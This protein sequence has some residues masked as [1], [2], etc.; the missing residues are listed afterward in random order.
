M[1]K[2]LLAGAVLLSAPLYAQSAPAGDVPSKDSKAEPKPDKD[3]KPLREGL[4][5]PS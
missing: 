4:I 5:A 3:V 1:L 2:A